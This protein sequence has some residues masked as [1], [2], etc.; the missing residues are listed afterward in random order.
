[1]TP[2]RE[3]L[4][5]YLMVRRAMGFRLDRA[6]KLLGQFIDYLEQRE[7]DTITIEHAVAWATQPAGAAWWHALRLSAVR[8]FAHYLATI[9]AATE[10]PPPGL[11]PGRVQRATPYL[12]SDTEIR[13]LIAAATRLRHPMLAATYPVLIGLLAATGIRIGEAIALDNSDLDLQHEVLTVRSG[14][15]GKTRLLP[16]HP[17]TADALR[18]Y[19]RTRDRLRPTP[20]SDT[21]LVSS[22]G[23]RLDQSRVS[24]MFNRLTRQTGVTARSSSCRPRIHDLRH[25][26]AVATIL[27]AYRRG[28][29]V[30][31]VLP[32]LATYLGHSDPKHTYWYL[33]AAPELLAVAAELLET[34]TGAR[35]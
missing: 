19:L 6:E 7:T 20:V 18:G 2:L 17:S 8:S 4:A 23:T 34:R 1:M 22:A 31:N 11:V 5:D 15:F 30:P 28:D 3:A 21:L 33:D 35:P 24:K 12:Y 25:G 13:A 9:D 10:V 16:L 26:F 14:K 27:T 32:R 29:H